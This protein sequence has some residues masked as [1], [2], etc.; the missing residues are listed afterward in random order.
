[1]FKKILKIVSIVLGGFVVI[2]GIAT[3]IYALTGG[4]VHKNVPIISVFFGDDP[5]NTEMKVSQPILGDYVCCVNYYPDDATSRLLNVEV[6]DEV[7]VIDYCPS[8]VEAGKDFTIKIKKDSRGNNIGGYVYLEFVPAGEDKSLGYAKLELFVDVAIPDNSLYFTGDNS[9][10]ITA[11]GKQFS[12]AMT[13]IEEGEE[14]KPQYIYLK[15]SLVNAFDLKDGDVNLK[16]VE[17]EYSYVNKYGVEINTDGWNKNFEIIPDR[18]G[19]YYQIPVYPTEGGV[20]DISAKMHRTAQIAKEFEVNKFGDL[21]YMFA[22]KSQFDISVLDNKILAYNK[23][24]NDYIEYFDT[25]AESY[26]YFSQYTNKTTG[27][28]YF[29]SVIEASELAK[30][31]N[32]VFVHAEAKVNVVAVELKNV[33]SLDESKTFYVTLNDSDVKT[34]TIEDLVNLFDIKMFIGGKDQD[35]DESTLVEYNDENKN[36]YSSMNLTPYLYLSYD[37]INSLNTNGGEEKYIFVDERTDEEYLVWE[38]TDYVFQRVYGFTGA[39]EDIPVLEEGDNVVGYLLTLKKA[40]EFVCVTPLMDTKTPSW[41][42]SFNVPQFLQTNKDFS[43]ALYFGFEIQGINLNTNEYI[44]K[45]SF[46]RISINYQDYVFASD[47]ISN[48]SFNPIQEVMSINSDLNI[49]IKDPCYNTSESDNIDNSPD[50][51]FNKFAEMFYY[52]PIS[53]D[54]TNIKNFNSSFI[55]DEGIRVEKIT[56]TNVMYFAD[57]ESNNADGYKKIATVGKYKFVNY[58]NADIGD[59]ANNNSQDPITTLV[60]ERIPTKS[61]DSYSTIIQALNASEDPVKL[62]AV[63]YLADKYG[64]PIDINGRLINIDESREDESNIPTLV[65]IRSTSIDDVLS[66]VPQV[67]I[68]SYVDQL[69]FYTN[70]EVDV[71]FGE[72]EFKKG[73]IKRNTPNADYGSAVVGSSEY[74]QISN[75]LKLKLLDKYNFTLYVSNFELE[76]G[77]SHQQVEKTTKSISNVKDIF[78]DTIKGGLS[79]EI[80]NANN[81]QLA[82]NLLAEDQDSFELTSVSGIEVVESK[83]IT[84][85]TSGDVQY[86]EYVIIA[87]DNVAT[88]TMSLD[89]K[90]S[91]NPY[92]P[93]LEISEKI[94]VR[95][96]WVT[97][98]SS[99]LEVK[100][101]KLDTS[102]GLKLENELYG[103]YASDGS[104][105]FGTIDAGEWTQYD[106]ELSNG[107]IPYTY[108]T[109]LINVENEGGEIKE[110]VNL[111][112]VDCSQANLGDVTETIDSGDGENIRLE[113]EFSSIYQYVNFHL[114]SPNS[115][116]TEYLNAV[117]GVKLTSGAQFS[118]NLNGRHGDY[119]YIGKH[120]FKYDRID[121]GNATVN[122]NGFI[123]N[124]TNNPDNSKEWLLNVSSNE[125]FPMVTENKIL[126]YGE[127]FEI[128]SDDKGNK[129]VVS[130]NY[131]YDKTEYNG[132]RVYINRLR[133]NEP[134]IEYDPEFYLGAGTDNKTIMKV[135][136]TENDVATKV[137]PTFVQGEDGGIEVYILVKISMIN[138]DS[139]S[140]DSDSDYKYVFTRVIKYN[141]I[142]EDIKLT[143]YNKSGELNTEGNVLVLPAGTREFDISLGQSSH[144]EKP[145]ILL[146]NE[147]ETHFFDNVTV[148]LETPVTGVKVWK[149]GNLIKVELDHFVDDTDFNIILSYSK[150]NDVQPTTLIYYCTIMADL[151]MTIEVDKDEA[152]GITKI[153]Q[154]ASGEYRITMKSGSEFPDIVDASAT[155]EWFE[156]YFNISDSIVGIGLNLKDQKYY[157][158]SANSSTGYIVEDKYGDTLGNHIIVFD[159]MKI[160]LNEGGSINLY[161]TNRIIQIA[162]IPEYYVSATDVKTIFDGAKL[163]NEV[164]KLSRQDTSN[165]NA[166]NETE[167]EDLEIIN[168]VTQGLEQGN[169]LTIT[170][171]VVKLAK[172][173]PTNVNMTFNVEYKGVKLLSNVTITIQG[174]S[175]EYSTIGNLQSK[176]PLTSDIVISV[177]EGTFDVSKYFETSYTSSDNSLS[178]YGTISTYCKLVEQNDQYNQYTYDIYYKFS[179]NALEVYTG[180]TLTLYEYEI[181]DKCYSAIGQVSSIN[182]EWDGND[183]TLY[184]PNSTFVVANYLSAKANN[185][186]D[187]ACEVVLLDYNHLRN[188]NGSYIWRD[189]VDSNLDSIDN[190]R[191]YIVCYKLGDGNYI[192][193]NKTLTIDVEEATIKCDS[194]GYN[195]AQGSILNSNQTIN[196][197]AGTF[198]IANYITVAYSGEKSGSTAQLV[199]LDSSTGLE[200]EIPTSL[201]GGYNKTYYI[202]YKVIN[203]VDNYTHLVNTGYTITITATEA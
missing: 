175:V 22:N 76:D 49:G 78:G 100:D 35:I 173:Q 182:S 112:I 56:Y 42:V 139:D 129:Y 11:G 190:N 43:K 111:T 109:N 145:Y 138:S 58:S 66:D 29:S 159:A 24:I 153:E 123:L 195:V 101:V 65:V 172:T 23:F 3:G 87:T 122:V 106:I 124:L 88:T 9:G 27:K 89:V 18:D 41:N 68:K 21:L 136:E 105:Q 146:D 32:F 91:V 155:L 191:K 157:A 181:T 55:N 202:A 193:T 127:E 20:I 183:L 115:V 179:S 126:I 162:I 73:F 54:N 46:S 113:N 4:F 85:E 50:G 147:Y 185:N 96:N 25:T 161:N 19:Y 13:T 67:T 187:V 120:S 188:E 168:I 8:Q 79:F 164:I 53:V 52:Q 94:G 180:Y 137:T 71:E 119:I 1:M 48:L 116:R 97:V 86:F 133:N 197:I 31:L 62:F 81:M 80:N 17:I 26:E 60:G 163:Y 33:T 98:S 160:Q 186:I 28:V 47:A 37:Y 108:T 189:T 134:D 196:A 165:T 192:S 118:N 2:V 152:N 169:E 7:G 5:A 150:P 156:Q 57:S 83:V 10:K 75:F 130:F 45:E 84:D 125:I 194:S 177:E 34:Y 70:S 154:L 15:S 158:S 201:N 203:S 170:N 39:H 143:K 144:S 140:D 6:H 114:K 174:V 16:P 104:I 128:Q 149:D 178:S 14:P 64:R 12:M 107:F 95:S 90:N 72:E 93:N 77:G 151:Q 131:V 199:L 176:S 167:Y 59:Q 74:V 198:D 184:V 110:S 36:L 117:A 40:E 51:I 135:L 148:R 200:V 92:S 38:G 102:A 63:V 132:Q 69:N 171:G 103:I 61:S 121:E 30:S 166:I 99:Q 82:L 141:L 44:Y 142:Q